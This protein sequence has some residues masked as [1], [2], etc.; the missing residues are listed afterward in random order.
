VARRK[1]K[2]ENS[3]SPELCVFFVSKRVFNFRCKSP[4]PGGFFAV[5]ANQTSNDP[6]EW[7]QVVL[8]SDDFV[9]TDQGAGDAKGAE[10]LRALLAS[11]DD[12]FDAAD[13]DPLGFPFHS[14]VYDIVSP[15][16]FDMSVCYRFD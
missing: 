9:E 15:I 3:V 2:Y 8:E 11:D 7:S 10:Y 12:A 5:S 16:W 13:Q 1:E 14:Y 4:T 6:T